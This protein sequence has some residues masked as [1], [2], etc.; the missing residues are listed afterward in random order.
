MNGEETD[1][2]FL[3]YFIVIFLANTIGAISGMGGGIIIKPALDMI[4]FHNLTQIVL[5][6]SIAVFVMSISSTLKQ[7][8]RGTKLDVGHVLFLSAGSIVGGFVGNKALTYLLKNVAENTVL[9]TQIIIMLV[10]LFL[11]L[12]YTN[13]SHFQLHWLNNPSFFGVGIL[14]GFFSVILGI[15]GGPINVSLLVL[16]FGFTLKEAMAYSIATIFFSQLT[17]LVTSWSNGSFV[18]LDSRFLLVILPAALL[19]GYV[20]STINTHVNDASVR[21]LYNAI[22]IGVMLLNV[23]NLVVA[24]GIIG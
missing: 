3:L 13:Y 12:L 4:G 10:I 5:Y 11:V 7:V 24:L 16:C 14:L 8:R 15:G 22:L 6:S 19:G 21:R 2:I 17:Q 9:V 18:Y 1:M 20:G 23:Y